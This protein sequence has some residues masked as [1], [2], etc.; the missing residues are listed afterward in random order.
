MEE[1]L[2]GEKIKAVIFDSDGVITKTA[3]VHAR[4]WKAAF[5]EYLR[6]REERDKE[7]FREFT[8]ENDY[9]PFVDGK[10]RYEGVRSFLESRGIHI[11]FGEPED[12][13]EKETVCGI[14]NRKNV[15]FVEVLKSEGVEVYDSTV[16]FIKELKSAGI[17]V[18]VASS[19]K[20][21]QQVLQAAG[22]EELFETRRIINPS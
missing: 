8:H 14:G 22:I 11:P 13:P 10:P 17:R 7:P 5:D 3:K 21:C 20:N 6:L 16:K 1:D 2:N 12:S 4:A 18:G 9:L 15:K 19:S